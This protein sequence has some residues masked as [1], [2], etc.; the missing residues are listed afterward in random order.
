MAAQILP[1]SDP[2]PWIVRLAALEQYLRAQA[3]A[4]PYWQS[5]VATLEAADYVDRVLRALRGQPSSV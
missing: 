3:R 4:D 1:V 2:D 5:A